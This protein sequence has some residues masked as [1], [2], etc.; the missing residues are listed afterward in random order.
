M[1]DQQP[2]Q[3]K[4]DK[5]LTRTKDIATIPGSIATVVIALIALIPLA[6]PHATLVFQISFAVVL[7]CLPLSILI[8]FFRSRSH[9]Y[10]ALFFLSSYPA[11]L[12]YA[13]LVYRS[14]PPEPTVTS[15]MISNAYLVG[16]FLW[17]FVL[18]NSGLT[19]LA[20]FRVL[21][22]A[23]YITSALQNKVD[24]SL[25]QMILDNCAN[26]FLDTAQKNYIKDLHD[27]V[28]SLS[29]A[30]PSPTNQSP[31]VDSKGLE[32]ENPPAV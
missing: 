10:N 28:K 22:I 4:F 8:F 32:N 27:K 26:G 2:Q 29:S 20:E 17:V 6:A 14:F 3:T 12:Y 16:C 13:F 19:M 1:P 11:I 7:L 18:F 9:F 21:I 24:T 25:F 5:W 15:N 31:A 23:V 30:P